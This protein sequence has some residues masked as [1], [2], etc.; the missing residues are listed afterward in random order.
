MTLRLLLAAALVVACRPNLGP[1]AGCTP[2]ASSCQGDRPSV[3]SQSQRWQPAGD[4]TCAAVGG[5][6]VVGDAGLAHCAAPSRDAG[7]E[8]TP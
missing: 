5:A 4:V 7:A 3:C 1:V 2:G 6:C 8:V